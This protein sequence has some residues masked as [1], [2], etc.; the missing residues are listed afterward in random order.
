MR[1]QQ[2]YLGLVLVQTSDVITGQI[3]DIPIRRSGNITNRNLLMTDITLYSTSTLSRVGT[4]QR[5]C[6]WSCKQIKYLDLFTT[7]YFR[8]KQRKIFGRGQDW[9][10]HWMYAGRRKED[11]ITEREAHQTGSDQCRVRKTEMSITAA[12][13][14]GLI[15]LCEDVN[16]RAVNTWLW[17]KSW[18][19]VACLLCLLLAQGL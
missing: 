18:K 7:I 4:R 16:G 6:R 1:S 14:L 3:F 5:E 11:L 10:L 17:L 9:C 13:Q 12:S 19:R 2:R 15:E 8:L